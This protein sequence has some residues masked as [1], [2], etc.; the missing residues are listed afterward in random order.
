[1]RS[2]VLWRGTPLN[3][4]MWWFFCV[5]CFFLFFLICFLFFLFLWGFCFVLFSF[6][7]VFWGFFLLFFFCS[8]EKSNI[9]ICQRH[10]SLWIVCDVMHVHISSLINNR[11]SFYHTEHHMLQYCAIYLDF[12][13][14]VIIPVSMVGTVTFLVLLI[15]KTARVAYR[16]ERVSRVHL[17]GLICIVIKVRWQIVS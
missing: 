12:I 14:D 10:A 8:I 2:W 16:V 4:W 9:S 3:S 1:M 17:D 7:V 6:C 13:Q 11:A 15:V 5:I